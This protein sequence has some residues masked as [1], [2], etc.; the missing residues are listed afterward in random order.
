VLTHSS[1]NVQSNSQISKSSHF[2]H[3][4]QLASSSTTSLASPHPAHG[5]S[6]PQ[7]HS[8][9]ALPTVLASTSLAQSAAPPLSPFFPQLERFLRALHPSLSALAIPLFNAGIDSFELLCL[10]NAFESE[11]LARF[12]Q[13][14]KSQDVKQEISNVHL[15]LLQKKH[16]EAKVGDW[17]G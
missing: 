4:P 7:S 11:T 8:S 10:F 9:F 13:L 1:T 3:Y 16:E 5:F 15:R 14:V 12:L 2:A 6:M 17:S